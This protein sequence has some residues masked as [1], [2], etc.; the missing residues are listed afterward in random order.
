MKTI[1]RHTLAVAICLAC[2]VTGAHAAI[3]NGASIAGGSLQDG[4]LF[5]NVWDQLA[6]TSYAIDLGT[7]VNSMYANQNSNQVWHLDQRF[8]NWAALTTDTL[9]FNVAGNNQYVGKNSVLDAVVLSS[10]TGYT[11]IYNAN[12]LGLGAIQNN[13]AARALALNIASG[14]PL[15]L[16]DPTLN[17]YAAN[18]NSISVPG[19]GQPY[20]DYLYW[21]KTE[22][23]PNY[24]GSA[25]VRNGGVDQTL[26][27]IYLH[28]P[29]G[30]TAVSTKAIVEKFNGYLTLDTSAATLTWHTNA[31]TAVPLPGAIWMFLSGLLATL[32]FQKRKSHALSA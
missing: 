6:Q 12:M 30:T 20:F 16:V 10:L 5:L 4:E 1:K 8:I 22:G 17:N 2:G 7:T 21:G 13:V 11:N 9:T 26:D 28:G 18:N 15:N 3:S 31:V 14:E 24:V 25:T 32:G 27:L 29:G 19:D 23:I